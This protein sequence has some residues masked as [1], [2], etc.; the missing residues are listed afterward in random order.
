VE[1]KM[2]LVSMGLSA[3][4]FACNSSKGDV[5]DSRCGHEMIICTIAGTGVGGFQGVDTLATETQL[6]GPNALAIDSSG[7][8]IIS[9]AANYLIR[10]FEDDQLISIV[11]QQR[12]GFSVAGDTNDTALNFVSGIDVGPDGLMYMVE[13]QGHHVTVVD[14]EANE[15]EVLLAGHESPYWNAGDEAPMWPELE[16]PKFEAGLG[17]LS[18]VAVGDD[19][20]VYIADAKANLIFSIS[21]DFSVNTVAGMDDNGFA[22][23]PNLDDLASDNHRLAGPQG[24]VFHDGALYVADTD[25][26][27]IVVVDLEEG[28]LTNVIG[29]TD[30]PGY[31]D[32]G[33]F[34][35]AQLDS[36]H[37][38]NFGDEG[39]M[40][41]SD[42]GNAALRVELLNG[43]IDTVAGRGA[44]A[45]DGEP[46]DA[47]MVSLG[48]PMGILYDSAGDLV[49]ADRDHAVIRRIH[50]PN[51]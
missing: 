35:E 34:A 4:V 19:G 16:T 3:L 7:R 50:Q 6:N 1:D 37:H 12:K 47:E 5:D 39:R 32:G 22:L 2:K 21:T 18:G 45:Y 43:T 20:T 28:T 13:G 25:R 44:G 24:L 17:Q 15:I 38:F 10:R 49:F 29:V 23:V 40:I 26:H 27:R 51:W 8:I 31:G 36:P 33:P 9:D 48:R 42:S 11:G 46:Q 41:V 14:I 30:R